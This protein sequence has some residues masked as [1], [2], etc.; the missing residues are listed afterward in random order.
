MQV[1]VLKGLNCL[2]PRTCLYHLTRYVNGSRTLETH[3]YKPFAYPFDLVGPS[4]ILWQP[5]PLLDE[6]A[7]AV[8]DGDSANPLPK[9]SKRRKGKKKAE[10]QH[11]Q[12]LVNRVVWVRCHPSIYDSVFAALQSSASSALD[13]VQK[14]SATEIEVELADLRGQVNAFEIM[15]PK[16]SQILKGA[17]SP[18][19]ED[20]REDFRKVGFLSPSGQS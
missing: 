12:E 20:D 18:V 3:I 11:S 10:P 17:L 5:L 1:L 13:V 19:G 14:S 16:C 8:T 7:S 4:T 15:G 2:S 9:K 6:A